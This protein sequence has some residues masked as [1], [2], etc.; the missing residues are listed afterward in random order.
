MTT[1][2]FDYRARVDAQ[3]ASEA[4]EQN[5]RNV[6]D[7]KRNWEAFANAT[8]DPMMDFD[9][10]KCGGGR[11]EQVGLTATITIW[12][13]CSNWLSKNNKHI[14]RVCSILLLPPS[15]SALLRHFVLGFVSGA[16]VTV[17]SNNTKFCYQ[18]IRFGLSQPV[19]SLCFISA[20]TPTHVQIH[21]IE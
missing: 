15:S 10:G 2:V 11:W 17:T 3:L 1:R 18:L 12:V 13:C 16:H 9:R 4:S 20:R 8:M 7:A 21:S 14:Q 5:R 19:S 6:L